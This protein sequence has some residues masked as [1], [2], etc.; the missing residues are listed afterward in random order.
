MRVRPLSVAVC[1]AAVA[2]VSLY[3]LLLGIYVPGF[4]ASAG[5]ASA[6]VLCIPTDGQEHGPDR[7]TRHDRG[8]CAAPCPVGAGAPAPATTAARFQPGG[9]WGLI[10]WTEDTAALPPAGAP[11]T[12]RARGPPAV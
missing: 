4:S 2:A 9:G 3:A 11:F 7:P 6:E 10:N 12:A 8:C 1:R 5:R